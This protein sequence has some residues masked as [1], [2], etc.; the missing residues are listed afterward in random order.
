MALEVGRAVTIRRF[1]SVSS[2]WT[3]HWRSVDACVAA[4]SSVCHDRT[5]PQPTAA[6]ASAS[7]ERWRGGTPRRFACVGSHQGM[8]S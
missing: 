3:S 2:V 4:E 7:S 8:A 1:Q 5:A 6:A